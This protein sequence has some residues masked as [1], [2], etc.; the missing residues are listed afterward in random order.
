MKANVEIAVF[1]S[2]LASH[3]YKMHEKPGDGPKYDKSFIPAQRIGDEED[4]AGVMLY[5]ASTAGSFCNGC[6]VVMDGG[7]LSILPSTY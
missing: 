7:R 6:V 2:D 5:L 4:M 1:P 3:L